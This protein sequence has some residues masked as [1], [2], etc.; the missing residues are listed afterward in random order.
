M[1]QQLEQP[2][3]GGSG[4]GELE[5]ALLVTVDF[6]Q[7]HNQIWLALDAP[8][9]HAALLIGKL[10]LKS[11]RIMKSDLLRLLDIVIRDDFERIE[12]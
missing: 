11:H 10:K 9:F 2:F 8:D 12:G 7:F 5:Q 1:N 6:S 3:G 4:H